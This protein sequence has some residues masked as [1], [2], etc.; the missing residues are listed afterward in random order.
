MWWRGCSTFD[1]DLVKVYLQSPRQTGL[2]T[3]LNSTFFHSNC[4]AM[5]LHHKSSTRAYSKI[6]SHRPRISLIPPPSQYQTSL[7]DILM[8]VIDLHKKVLDSPFCILLLGTLYNENFESLIITVPYWQHSECLQLG[9]EGQ[10][11]WSGLKLQLICHL[12]HSWWSVLT[13]FSA[14]YCD[15]LHPIKLVGIGMVF[16]PQKQQNKKC[17]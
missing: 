17:L 16:H 14:I 12:S 1:R 4:F 2:K 5:L 13:K 15:W 6:W 11:C 10:S 7:T 9:A 3:L 8:N